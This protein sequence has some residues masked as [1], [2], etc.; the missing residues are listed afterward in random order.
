MV[1]LFPQIQ[2]TVVI[3]RSNLNELGAYKLYP[4]GHIN[5]TNIDTGSVE[6]R[7]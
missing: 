2:R 7:D 6:N 3:M 5:I 1:D 4:R